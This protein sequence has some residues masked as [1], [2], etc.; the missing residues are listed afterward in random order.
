MIGRKTTR[1]ASKKIGKPK[2]SAATPS[3][4]GARCSPNRVIRV[5]ART[6]APPVVSSSRPT[7]TPKA[8]SRATEPSVPLKPLSRAPGTSTIGM[9]AA[10]AV[11][12]LTR[13][14]EMK[15]CSLTF[16]IRNSNSATAAAAISRSVTVPKAGSAST[17]VLLV[18]VGVAASSPRVHLGA[19][20]SGGQAP[21]APHPQ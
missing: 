7:I 10:T 9:P 3:A 4:I 13:T 12:V 21:L 5:S 6:C 17:G 16:M 2:I 18:P 1:P 8:T 11:S 15:A 19:T 14:R 20:H